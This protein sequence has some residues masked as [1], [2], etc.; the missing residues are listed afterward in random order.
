MK[1]DFFFDE[2]RDQAASLLAQGYNYSET[3]REVGCNPST[4]TRWM[5]ND[6]FKQAVDELS[7]TYGAASKAH[8]LR[9]INQAIR[10]KI[11]KDDNIDLNGVSFMDLI[12]EARMQTEGLRLGIL[13]TLISADEKAGLMAGSGSDGSTGLLES[14]D[15]ETE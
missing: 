13:N 2:Q 11:D 15:P 3:A 4:I 8:R 6:T 1:D 12:K 7:L 5:K 10:Q 9:L 14:Q